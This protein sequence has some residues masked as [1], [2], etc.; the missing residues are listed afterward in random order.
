MSTDEAKAVLLQSNWGMQLRFGDGMP[1][2]PFGT[3][4]LQILPRMFP[5]SKWN[6]AVMSDIIRSTLNR[7]DK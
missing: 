2:E 4:L 1:F 6:K 7:T 3:E 5:L